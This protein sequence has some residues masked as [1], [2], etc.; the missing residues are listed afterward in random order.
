MLCDSREGGM[1]GEWEGAQPGGNTRVLTAGSC[2]CMAE[3]S[4]VL[5]RGYPPIKNK[6]R[7]ITTI[8][9]LI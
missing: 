2:C 6:L 9:M 1:G 5:Q 8:N 7:M 4:T 3:A